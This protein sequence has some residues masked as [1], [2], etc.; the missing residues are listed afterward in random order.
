MIIIILFKR[1]VETICEDLFLLS[2]GHKHNLALMLV[3]SC[4]FTFWQVNYEVI[5]ASYTNSRI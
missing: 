2:I 3:K 5:S 1:K 4:A